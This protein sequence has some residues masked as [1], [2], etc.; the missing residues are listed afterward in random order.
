[1]IK[2]VIS[3]CGPV[4]AGGGVVG[5]LGLVGLLSLPQAASIAAANSGT[6]VWT[7]MVSILTKKEA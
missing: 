5:L 1:V 7:L 3:N 6:M 4:E 2:V